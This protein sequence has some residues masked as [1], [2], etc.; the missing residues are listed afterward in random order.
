MSSTNITLIKT[1]ISSKVYF[2]KVCLYS[3]YT[4]AT[5]PYRNAHAHMLLW[6]P[7]VRQGQ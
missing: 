1:G 5:L 7:G 6:K 4:N 2:I 3:K